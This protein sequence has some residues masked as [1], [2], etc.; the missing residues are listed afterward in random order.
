MKNKLIESAFKIQKSR[1]FMFKLFCLILKIFCP[2]FH[3]FHINIAATEISSSF[4]KF[5]SYQL[6]WET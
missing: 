5:N 2:Q 4:R 6:P 1:I 3:L